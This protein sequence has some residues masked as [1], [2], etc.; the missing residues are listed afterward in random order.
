MFLVFDTPDLDKAYEERLKYMNQALK[1]A[2]YAAPVGV[3]KCTG[4]HFY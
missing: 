3:T 4:K 1:N 2:K